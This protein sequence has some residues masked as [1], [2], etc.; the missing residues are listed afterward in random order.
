MSTRFEVERAR[1]NDVAIFVDYKKGVTG[2]N[3]IGTLTIGF[4]SVS[5][6]TVDSSHEM[7]ISLDAGCDIILTA[8]DE[9][10]SDLYEVEKGYVDYLERQYGVEIPGESDD[11]PLVDLVLPDNRKPLQERSG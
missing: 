6:M 9:N 3:G 7:R 1:N 5:H 4:V 11:R 8:S 10:Y 2:G